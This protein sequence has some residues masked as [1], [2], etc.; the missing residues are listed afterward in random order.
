MKKPITELKS[1]GDLAGVGNLTLFNNCIDLNDGA[2]LYEWKENHLPNC[3]TEQSRY[4]IEDLQEKENPT[5]QE[6]KE[7]E[8]LISEYGEE[9]YCECEPYQWYIIDRNDSD[10]EYLNQE[11]DL[12]IFYSETLG[13][14]I[15]PVYHFGTSWDILGLK[16]GYVNI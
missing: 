8:E 1:W 6:K 7:L 2:V 10:I 5:E 9:P 16:G 15:L 4:K 12:D 14:H 11:Y 3:E 13:L